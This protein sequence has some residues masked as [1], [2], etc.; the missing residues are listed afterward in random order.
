LL[1]NIGPAELAVLASM[2]LLF[3]GGKK[4][5]ELSKGVAQSIREFRGAVRDQV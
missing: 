4:L 2:V 3:T 1:K 5:P